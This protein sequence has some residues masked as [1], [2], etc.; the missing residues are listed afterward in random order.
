MYIVGLMNNRNGPDCKATPM[1]IYLHK[2]QMRRGKTIKYQFNIQ[3]VWQSTK[4][5]K[6]DYLLPDYISASP[7]TKFPALWHL[8]PSMLL[9]QKAQ[10]TREG[11]PSLATPYLWQPE[12]QILSPL[13]ALTS[14]LQWNYLASLF[15]QPEYGPRLLL[16]HP[17]TNC[18][19]TIKME[20]VLSG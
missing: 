14:R 7:R 2:A 19:S 13:C 1:S 6:L 11:G 9:W 16:W 10:I 12:D 17:F 18:D 8:V 3:Q 4:Q 5:E 15:F 20:V